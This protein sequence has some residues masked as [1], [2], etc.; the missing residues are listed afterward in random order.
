MC[1]GRACIIDECVTSR[2]TP[3][4]PPVSS[5][6]GC[7]GCGGPD[8]AERP[9]RAAHACSN[10]E[11]IDPTSCL[12]NPD[13]AQLPATVT[14]VVHAATPA[15]SRSR[16]QAIADLVAAEYGQET[17]LV[18]KVAG[19]TGVGWV[20]DLAQSGVSTPGCD[21]GHGGM[22]RSWH[23]SDCAWRRTT[24]DNPATSSDTA[25]N[26]AVP[27][28]R[29]QL[30]A[31]PREPAYDAVYAYIRELGDHMPPDPVHRN[32]IIWQAVNA[33]LAMMQPVLTE[34]AELRTEYERVRLMLHASRGQRATAQAAASERAA[35]LEEARDILEAAGDNGAHGDDRPA[36]APA[37][38]RLAARA[39]EAEAEARRLEDLVERLGQTEVQQRDTIARVRALHDQLA[40]G[41][42]L[43]DPE[44]E[45]TRGGAAQRIAAAL[46]GWSPPAGQTDG[47]AR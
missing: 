29:D 7:A 27:A 39:T 8:C 6:A 12:A 30:A 15:D 13:R 19:G 31:S 16:A 28:L 21:C 34:L 32:A 3:D 17:S 26:P 46:D 9:D 24:P 23:A 11:G 10:C 1:H 47:D 40:N 25:D 22:G 38:Q 18:I 2:T 41:N 14:V 36:V 37:V 4:N 5:C 44:D 20:A 33:A 35:L 45:M 43:T 42:D